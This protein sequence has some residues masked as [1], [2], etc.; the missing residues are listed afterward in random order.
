MCGTVCPADLC[1]L[2]SCWSDSRCVRTCATELMPLETDTRPLPRTISRLGLELR[3]LL[4]P[5]VLKV[6]LVA[7]VLLL[8]TVMACRGLLWCRVVT[9]TLSV[10]ETEADERLMLKALQV[11]LRWVGNGVSLLPPPTALTWL[12][13]LARTPRG[14]Y[15]RLML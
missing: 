5:S 9:V 12:C 13:C 14:Q 7:T 1:R 4:R 10:V 15:R 11:S 2:P 3:S 6:T 8:T